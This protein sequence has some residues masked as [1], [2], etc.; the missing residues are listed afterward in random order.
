LI[1]R[2]SWILGGHAPFE[3]FVH[4]VAAGK[5]EGVFFTDDFRCPVH[6]SDLAAAILELC[7]GNR[8]GLLHV[9][10][11]E[12]LSRLELA[13]L[14]AERDGLDPNALPG[15]VK[16]SVAGD[17]GVSVRLDARAARDLLETPLR[18]AREFLKER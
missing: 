17:T 18:G 13:Q 7:A 3:T 4:D 11:P 5:S 16:A 8:S 14:I 9:A 1:V 15:G 12:L 2:T 10:G 6:A